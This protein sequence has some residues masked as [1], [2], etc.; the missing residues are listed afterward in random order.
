[1][2]SRKNA[3]SGQAADFLS[4]YNNATGLL[5]AWLGA[6]SVGV[7]AFLFTHDS[8]LTKLVAQRKAALVAE[9]FALA[10]ACQ[11]AITFL[12]K[13][14]EWGVYDRYSPPE[15][16][17]W[18]TRICDKISEWIWLDL[19]ADVATIAF[20]AWGSVTVFYVLVSA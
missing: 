7:P 14:V 20:L 11:V 4:S 15:R 19:I 12:N 13:Y 8:V 5:R 9:I 1:M 6:Y 3:Q 2:T 16:D 17:N 18:Y 10:I